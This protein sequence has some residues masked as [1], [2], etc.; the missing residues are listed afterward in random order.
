MKN[1]ELSGSVVVGK[2]ATVMDA[3]IAQGILASSGIESFISNP[4]MSNLYPS[5][6][7]ITQVELLVRREDADLAIKIINA[8]FVK[9]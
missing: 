9:E 2:Y 6:S 1:D 5:L 3:E 8:D 7:L 4:Y